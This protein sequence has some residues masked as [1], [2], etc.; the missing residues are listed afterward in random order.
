MKKISVGLLAVALLITS[1]SFA[2][3][4]Y[5]EVPAAAE[6]GDD[7]FMVDESGVMCKSSKV[8]SAESQK[9]R[10]AQAAA[11]KATRQQEIQDMRRQ[12]R[13]KKAEKK[14]LSDA[15]KED[16]RIQ[17]QNS[18]HTKR[19][20]DAELAVKRSLDEKAKKMRRK[21]RK[22]ELKTRRKQRNE[23]AVAAEKRCVEENGQERRS[24]RQNR[25]ALRVSW[26]EAR[27][28][29]AEQDTQAGMYADL[30]KSPAWPVY[31]QSYENTDLLDVVFEYKYAT[32]C[33][34][35][36]KNGTKSD[37][38]RLAFGLN[39]ITVQDILLASKLAVAGKVIQNDPIQNPI[40]A[41]SDQYLKYM[42]NQVITFNGKAE[43]YGT[44]LEFSRYILKRDIAV[45][46]E[47]PVLYK[48]HRLRMHTALSSEATQPNGIIANGAFGPAAPAANAFLKRYGADPVRFVQDILSS[49][50]IRELG[51]SATGLGDVAFF[52]NGQF[53]STW[54]EKAV[55]GVRGQF[56][57]GKRAIQAKLWAPDLGNGGFTEITPFASILLSCHKYLNPHLLTQVSFSLPAH[58]ERRIPRSVKQDSVVIVDV[59]KGNQAL[60]QNLIVLGDRVNLVNN[61]TGEALIN[62][63]TA[64]AFSEYDTT[65]LGLADT[66][67]KLRM[68]KG[69]ELKIRVGNMFERCLSRRGFLDLY[70]DFRAKQRDRL[71]GA[72]TDEFNVDMLR[73]DSNLLEHRAGIEYSY[74][75]DLFTRLRLGMRYTFAGR[76]V[77]KAFDAA[78]ALNYAF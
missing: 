55:I 47:I 48:R 50:G 46:V 43:Q 54:F 3:I 76:D 4:E 35:S 11:R 39:P 52:V 21:E 49:K 25:D 51:G 18:A 22:C 8:K 67:T 1:S 19:Q 9:L 69:T 40:A 29:Q 33:Y 7:E 58:V 45:G 72:A 59:A 5:E 12:T 77:A 60:A 34:D 30:Y 57:T 75:F 64:R 15:K 65:I 17:Q 13:M 2:R 61:A 23:R 32:D 31:A 44:I 56:P 53:N 63:Q 16:R 20:R 68:H 14:R 70:Y 24:A 62:G 78:G 6:Q 42:A 36:Y 66:I 73:R 38:S 10:R 41:L 26:R 74:Q 71:S 27:A 37:I 28:L